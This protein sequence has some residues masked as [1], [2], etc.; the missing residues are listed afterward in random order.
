MTTPASKWAAKPRRDRAT[1]G[2]EVERAR[3]EALLDAAL[4]QTFPASDPVTLK[5]CGDVDPDGARGQADPVPR[6]SG[7][8]DGHA[9]SPAGRGAPP[10]R[11][12]G[13]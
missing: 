12:A 10:R 6:G 5:A 3:V 4:M 8:H 13:G 2:R 11:R 1:A 9:A 7:V